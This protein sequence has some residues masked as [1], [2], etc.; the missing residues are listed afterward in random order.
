[1]SHSHD[2]PPVSTAEGTSL[3]DQLLGDLVGRQA[4]DL[5]LKPGRPPLLRVNGVLTPL[6]IEALGPDAVLRMLDPVIPDRLRVRLEDDL[7][8]DFGYGVPGV[9]RFRASVFCQRGTRAAV[10]RRVPFDFP[11]LDDWGLPPV[12]QE[13][14]KVKQG[15]VLVTGP[16]G[17]GKSS[18]LAALMGQITETRPHHI[19]TIEDPIEFLINDNM[20]SVS[21]REIGIDTPDF[22]SA[23]R[24]VL[25]QD[26]DVIMV[27]EMRDEET[28]R[29][30][31]TAAETGHLVLSTLHT[32]DAVQTVDRIISNFPENN[33]RQI[34]QQLSA[35]LEAV[36][37]LQLVPRASGSGM[38]AAVEIL[39]RTPQ[40]SKLILDGEFQA[41]QEA[42]ENS[43]SFYKMQSMN[44]SL[45]ALVLHGTITRK[46]ALAASPNASDLDLLIRK[47]AGAGGDGV[48]EG[49]EMAEATCDFSTILKL[50]EVKK[51]Y[52]ELQARHTDELAG[53]DHEIAQLRDQ[54]AGASSNDGQLAELQQENQRLTDQIK[55]V[56]DEY[57]AKLKQ[58]SERFK[59][60]KTKTV[61]AA[62]KQPEP[63]AEKKGFFRR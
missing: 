46:S 40:T 41:L 44:Q 11:S 23:L 53:R 37:S 3:L 27:G 26:P 47:T 4:S 29:T 9:S 14:C 55:T 20:G 7:A 17:S 32:N 16:T 58:L 36:V 13:F 12:L 61:A 28:T 1:V 8:I 54:L 10:F 2:Q 22:P 6:E 31:L 60:M 62:V 42:I 24:N 5:H 43:V 48:T 21:Q 15:L 18:T 19:V 30:V 39:R 59:S 33:H 57:E 49:D 25:R 52:D 56:R 50:Q 35:C 45:T 34:R 51:H 63:A 38:A